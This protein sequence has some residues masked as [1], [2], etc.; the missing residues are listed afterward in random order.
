M[1]EMMD[2]EMAIAWVPLY[3]KFP[4]SKKYDERT[5]DH[6][7]L[8]NESIKCI[9]GF[10]MNEYKSGLIIYVLLIQPL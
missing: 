7:S 10:E 3:W 4:F 5:F 8:L 2:G 1:L 6:I 9:P